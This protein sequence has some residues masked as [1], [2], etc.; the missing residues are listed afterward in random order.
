MP[1]YAQ[2][3]LFDDTDIRGETVRL[4][5]SYRAVVNNHAYPPAVARLLG[6]FL[7]ASVLLGSTI[8]FDGRLVLQA[9]GSGGLKVIVAECRY[10]RTIRGIA[11]MDETLDGQDFASLLGEGTLV[12][13]VEP[14]VGKSYQ[15]LVPL[16]G[17]N[18]AACLE[19][20][21]LQ[22]EQLM[23]RIWLAADEQRA[24]GLLLQQL[25]RQLVRDLETRARQWEH[26]V[27]LAD[28]TRPEELLDLATETLLKRLYVAEPVRLQAPS[29]VTFGCSCSATRTANALV[30]LGEDEVDSLFAEMVEVVMGCEFCG[31]QYTFTQESLAETLREGEVPH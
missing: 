4:G 14:T 8:K 10:D 2:R 1:D 16:T 18:L 17:S 6:E 30:L 24:G 28:T 12:M 22:S 5:D 27:I 26:A 11:R 23:T 7:A 20:Y 19:H 25:P 15:S 29:P 21:F 9:R 31:K 3:F 13:T